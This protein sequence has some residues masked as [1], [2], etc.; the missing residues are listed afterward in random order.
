MT[1]L[2][3]D[4]DDL[5][6]NEAGALS[7]AQ[8]TRLRRRRRGQDDGFSAFGAVTMFAAA[9][10]LLFVNFSPLVP[11]IFIPLLLLAFGV[12]VGINA[13][14]INNDLRDGVRAAEGRVQLI[15]GKG[16]E[17]GTIF[18]VEVEGQKF[19]LNREAFLAFKN[20][21]PYRVYYVPHSKLILS[22]EW[23]RD[24]DPFAERVVRLEAAPPADVVTGELSRPRSDDRLGTR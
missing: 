13:W 18:Y 9:F 23:L 17:R 11:F 19:R 2:K 21:D 14:R 6:A 4:A 22:V 5:A 1:A 10:M 24:D 12:F 8:V 7:P 3:F 15:V 20:G 16:G